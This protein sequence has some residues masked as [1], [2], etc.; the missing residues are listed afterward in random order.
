MDMCCVADF[1]LSS[2]KERVP[3]LDLSLAFAFLLCRC[4]VIQC[5]MKSMKSSPESPESSR[6]VFCLTFQ[7][8]RSG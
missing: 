8:V 6:F 5:T 1:G 7:P 3:F 2:T 4:V